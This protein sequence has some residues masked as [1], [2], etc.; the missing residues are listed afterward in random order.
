MIA[1]GG[2]PETAVFTGSMPA[3]KEAWQFMALKLDMMF[4]QIRN[5]HMFHL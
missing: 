2:H 4:V 1:G 3:N 5:Q